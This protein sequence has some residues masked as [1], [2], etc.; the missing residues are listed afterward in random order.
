MFKRYI[1]IFI[2]FLILLMPYSQSLAIQENPYESAEGAILIERDSGR[3]LYS[4]N[5]YKKLPMAST[6]KIM[7]ALIAIEKGD[8]DETVIIKDD[9][10][11]VEGSSIYLKPGEKIT[12]KDL[13]YGLILRSGNDAATA[14]AHHIAGS[15]DNFSV[16][17][18]E[19]SK[20]IGAKDTN[21]TNPHG[22]HSEN[23]YTTAYDL[24]LISQEALKNE[25]FREISKSIDYI[26]QRDL[27]SH[28]YNKNKALWQY[29]GGDGVKIGYTQ[30]AGRCLVA[31]ATRNNM[32]L[33]AVV[34]N[35]NNWF[36]DCYNLFDYGFDNYE[37][38][39]ILRKDNY[40]KNISINNGK[41]D[42]LPVVINKNFYYPLKREEIEEVKIS[43]KTPTNLTAPLK[44]G[45][46][47]GEI[48]ITLMDKIIYNSTMNLSKNI[49]EKTVKD[50]IVNFINDIF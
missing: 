28:F 31:S 4:K 24:A 47:I 2:I 1:S 25:T 9:W 6:T 19:R 50:K 13:V 18:N 16:L 12:L 5:I 45:E 49:N 30:A 22:L 34:L 35:D 40:I 14:I 42:R 20:E 33:I 32:Q 26:S 37:R 21:F 29:D 7:T 17:M 23:H 46:S 3:I 41:I 48:N 36:N 44:K 43:I 8:L 38:V 11:N 39:R 15:I 27:N 10:T